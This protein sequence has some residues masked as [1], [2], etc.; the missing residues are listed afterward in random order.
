[1]NTTVDLTG[2]LPDSAELGL[3]DYP[4]KA[5]MREGVS[6]WVFDENGRFGFPR[7]CLEAVGPDFDPKRLQVNLA[8]ADGRVLI[9]E[10]RG[11]AGVDIDGRERRTIWSGGPLEFRLIAPWKGWS[12][13]Y[14]GTAIETRSAATRNGRTGSERRVRLQFA[15]RA[16]LA[17]PPWRAEEMSVS[18]NRNATDAVFMGGKES[19]FES[20]LRYEQLIRAEGWVRIDGEELPFQGPGLRVHRQ[21]F[22]NLTGFTG[23][24]WQSALFPS[25]K[26]FSAIWL[27]PNNY[28]PGYILDAGRIL[29]AR[30]V[31]VSWM[32][33][34][35]PIPGENVSLVLESELGRHEI[36]AEVAYSRYIPFGEEFE[37]EGF[38][39]LNWQQGGVRYC[40][41]GEETIGSIERSYTPPAAHS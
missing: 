39:P 21:G 40:W 7:V 24:I 29:P 13:S 34:M 38:W 20:G 22:R 36:Q 37:T 4:H 31:E 2:G 17:A 3:A 11:T 15:I 27:L 6:V 33:S 10:D 30:P 1:M 35:E 19:G 18:D 26:G 5:D 14:D 8:F 23:H 25:G 41:D 16:T 32:K 12:V 9:G 28:R